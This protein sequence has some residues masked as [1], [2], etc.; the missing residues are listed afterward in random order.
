MQRVSAASKR[1]LVNFQS[2]RVRFQIIR[3]RAKGVL[4]R[5]NSA[6]KPAPS[7]SDSMAP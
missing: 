5:E 1:R 2:G 4:F 6:G 3:G 7:E